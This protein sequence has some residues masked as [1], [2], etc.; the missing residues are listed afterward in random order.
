VLPGEAL[1][2]DVDALLPD[3]LLLSLLFSLAGFS[4]EES[5]PL[6]DVSA[7]CT[8]PPPLDPR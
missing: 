2:D 8:R 4:A 1:L 5:P 3:V 6:E 7:V